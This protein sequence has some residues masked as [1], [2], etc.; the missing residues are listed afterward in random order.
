MKLRISNQ[1]IRL[2]INQDDLRQLVET[3]V[4]SATLG[5]PTLGS[6]TYTL[7][8]QASSSIGLELN[9]NSIKVHV[10][11]SHIDEWNETERVG[12]EQMA[13]GVRVLLE[14]DFQCLA[15]RP[16]EDESRNFKHPK[17]NH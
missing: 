6:F 1:S 9:N 4:L 11:Q 2:R 5:N 7:Q 14:K 16:N 3:G 10:P 17:F 15:E 8:A 13:S 12:F